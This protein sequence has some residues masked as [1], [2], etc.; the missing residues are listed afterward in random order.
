MVMG[1]CT[2]VDELRKTTSELGMV[3][4]LKSRVH[5]SQFGVG[6]L[7]PHAGGSCTVH[8]R[9]RVHNVRWSWA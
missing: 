6:K 8:G 1:E 4:W 7:M 2:M 5:G 3:N 9:V